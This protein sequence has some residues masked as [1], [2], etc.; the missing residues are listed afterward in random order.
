MHS[1]ATKTFF[2]CYMTN[3]FGSKTVVNV[4]SLI[5][6][7]DAE[8]TQLNGQQSN[9]SANINLIVVAYLGFNIPVLS[10]TFYQIIQMDIM[11]DTYNLQN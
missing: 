3:S 1:K 6:S 10:T 2:S 11:I 7:H 8:S 9:F 4:Y 5:V